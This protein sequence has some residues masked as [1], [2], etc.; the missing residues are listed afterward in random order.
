M[1]EGDG[2]VYN[3]A[4][5]AFL[6][7]EIDLDAHT[8]KLALVTGYTPNID[9]DHDWSD[10]SGDEVSDASYAAGGATLAS[11][12]V[13]LDSGNDYGKFDAADVTWSGLDVGT[14]SHAVLYDDT[15]ASDVLIAY[16]V[17]STAS[18]GGDYTIQWHSDGILTLA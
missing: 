6:A 3:E 7:G 1:A 11:K 18:N 10:V 9:T 16:W 2:F 14:P 12:V 13:S 4:K 17:L 15:H 8:L 5:R